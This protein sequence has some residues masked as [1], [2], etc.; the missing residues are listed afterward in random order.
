[1]KH[2]F[3]FYNL[4]YINKNFKNSYFIFKQH[5]FIKLYIGLLLKYNIITCVIKKNNFYL[6]F[7]NLHSPFKLINMFRKSR[8]LILKKKYLNNINNKYKDFIVMNDLGLIN[9][10]GIRLHNKGGVLFNRIEIFLNNVN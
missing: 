7:I 8:I 4:L 1:M 9:S 6:V 3:D 10:N 5:K 2:Y